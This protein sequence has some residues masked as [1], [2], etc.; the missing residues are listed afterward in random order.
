LI[1]LFRI[2][3]PLVDSETPRNSQTYRKVRSSGL[4]N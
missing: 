1:L 4:P 2:L 3:R